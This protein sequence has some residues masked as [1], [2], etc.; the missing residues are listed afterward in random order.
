MPYAAPV[1]TYGLKS[2]VIEVSGELSITRVAAE[3]LVPD[4]DDDAPPPLEA[5]DEHAATPAASS[6]AD[7]TATNRLWFGNLLFILCLS[8]RVI[9][10]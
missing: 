2:W 9:E 7:A 8:S 5:L 4:D 6:P 3:L 1:D 10:G